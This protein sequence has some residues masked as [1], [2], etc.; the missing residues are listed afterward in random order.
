MNSTIGRRAA[1]LGAGAL[2]LPHPARAAASGP[3]RIG[4]LTDLAGPYSDISGKGCVD[5][6]ELAIED[7]GGRVLRQPIELLKADHQNKPDVGLAIARRW[8]DEDG[9]DMIAD[10][11]NSAVALGVQ[12]LT[13]ERN[14]VVM[15]SGSGSTVLTGSGC[16]PNGIQWTYDTYSTSSST[17]HAL[18]TQGMA[19]WFL[20]VVDYTFGHSL[21][22]DATAVVERAGGKVLGAVRHPGGTT[23]FSS[24]LLQAQASGAKVVGLAN[25]GNDFINCAKQAVEFGINRNGVAL[26]PLAVSINEIKALG[27]QQAQGMVHTEPFYWN[28]SD[29]SRHLSSRFEARLG[30]PP[31]MAQAGAYSLV[32]NYLRAV[33]KAGTA[34]ADPVLARLHADEVQDDFT[35]SGRVRIDGRMV[36]DMY[37]VRVKVPS[38]SRSEWDLYDL[39]RVIPGDEAFRPL[40]AGGCPL[41]R[42]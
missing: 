22:A 28:T 17:A 26:A 27:L 14:K 24:Y 32:L 7:V 36:H 15:F 1:L 3:V 5:G 2:A 11:N 25:A 13:R 42:S 8:Y 35:P 16:S 37:L 21:Q 33:E 20:I 9:V 39:V 29:A 40:A 31:T 4:V 6:A 19:T 30:K 18:T 34:Q 23:D 10:V 12:T 41:V 38:A